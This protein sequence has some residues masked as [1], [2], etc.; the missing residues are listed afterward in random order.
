MQVGS[1]N[2]AHFETK[3]PNGEMEAQEFRSFG[4]FSKKKWRHV[5]VIVGTLTSSKSTS[6]QLHAS[7]AK[8][9]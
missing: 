2:W 6:N 5:D 7:Q 3:S 8:S 1:V 9:L 4:I